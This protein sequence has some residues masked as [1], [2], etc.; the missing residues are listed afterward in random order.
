M[1]N[2]P[3]DEAC[4]TFANAASLKHNI[5]YDALI[6]ASATNTLISHAPKLM[7][8]LVW[9]DVSLTVLLEPLTA[10]L[11]LYLTAFPWTFFSLYRSEFLFTHQYTF[12]GLSKHN[13]VFV[14]YVNQGT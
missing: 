1:I 13:L 6:F 3:C 10:K 11:L 9:L 7:P 4:L 5:H 2:P 12:A 8:G 14:Q